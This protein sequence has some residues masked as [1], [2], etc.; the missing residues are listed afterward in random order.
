MALTLGGMAHAEPLAPELHELDALYESGAV[1]LDL[2]TNP[3]APFVQ[4]PGG[5]RLYKRAGR[6][7]AEDQSGHKP[8]LCSLA[9]TMTLRAM[10]ETCRGLARPDHLR[11]M[12]TA[13]DSHIPAIAENHI[14]P[15]PRAEIRLIVAQRMSDE[16][17]RLKDRRI[18][19]ERE[20]AKWIPLMMRIENGTFETELEASLDAPRLPVSK[21]CLPGAVE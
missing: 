9:L 12:D 14:P 8:L 10:A 2:T 5:V 20:M 16:F 1:E 11:V 6:I 4:L 21:P 7:I 15:R 18:C 19:S 3:V 17:L 13:I